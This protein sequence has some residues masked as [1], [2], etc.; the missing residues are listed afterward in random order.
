MSRVV[1]QRL[2]TV[3]RGTPA[4]ICLGHCC[5]MHIF[6]SFTGSQ[7][8]DCWSSSPRIRILNQ[9]PKWILL[10]NVTA[11]AGAGTAAAAS[12]PAAC[13]DLWCPASSLYQSSRYLYFARILRRE[14]FT[15]AEEE[16]WFSD[17]LQQQWLWVQTLWMHKPQLSQKGLPAVPRPLGCFLAKYLESHAHG[18]VLGCFVLKDT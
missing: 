13:K 11:I 7:H 16:R 18:W 1:E 5:K 6:K 15:E 3:T 10:S 14:M 4:I 12:G 9:P 8:Q 2:S 17:S